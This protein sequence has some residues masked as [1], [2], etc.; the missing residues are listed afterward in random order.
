MIGSTHSI[1]TSKEVDENLNVYTTGNLDVSYTLSE[2]NV[3]FTNKI[4]MSIDFK[5]E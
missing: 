4:P 1:F 5:L 2:E 3:T